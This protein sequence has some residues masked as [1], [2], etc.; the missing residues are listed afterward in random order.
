MSKLMFAVDL[1]CFKGYR[2][3]RDEISG[4]DRVEKVS[5]FNTIGGHGR[6]GDRVSDQAGRF[7][8]GTNGK[9]G[10]MSRGEHHGAV[11]ESERRLVKQLADKLSDLVSQEGCE[12]WYLAASK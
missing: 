7:A 8:T 2:V 4:S 1:G 9:A 6:F 11:T 5:H 10:G 12:Q 3:F